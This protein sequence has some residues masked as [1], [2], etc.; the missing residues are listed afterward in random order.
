[1]SSIRDSETSSHR[2]TKR[3]TRFIPVTLRK[4][5]KL[6]DGHG[7]RQRPELPTILRSSGDISGQAAAIRAAERNL[8]ARRRRVIAG[9]AFDG[10]GAGGAGQGRPVTIVGDKVQ[11]LSRIVRGWAGFAHAISRK[12]HLGTPSGASRRSA[13]AKANRARPKLEGPSLIFSP[14]SFTPR[15]YTVA[16]GSSRILR[17]HSAGPLSW[18]FAPPEST[19]TVTG[20]SSTVNS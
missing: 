3:T 14:K 16:S 5:A 7:L 11:S 17:C 6:A 19:A 12:K 15:C 18:T 13:T 1:V 10:A 20:M 2:Y 9:I 8:T 4:S